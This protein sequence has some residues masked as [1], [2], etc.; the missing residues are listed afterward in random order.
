M[1]H[2]GLA[3]RGAEQFGQ[4]LSL[5]RERAAVAQGRAG[6]VPAVYITQGVVDG[7]A[8]DVAR[9]AHAS[10]SNEVVCLLSLWVLV[11]AIM[12]TV[13]L[14]NGNVVSRQSVVYCRHT[15][16]RGRRMIRWIDWRELGRYL[17]ALAVGLAIGALLA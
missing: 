14:R 2:A 10:S 12:S 8:V 3:G 5:G 13:L 16:P 15:K 11:Y 9:S 4:H 17:L 1:V 7:V 6:E